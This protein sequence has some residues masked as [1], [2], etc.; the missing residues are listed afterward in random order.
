MFIAFQEQW[1]T[2]INGFTQTY[3]NDGINIFEHPNAEPGETVWDV[4]RDKAQ[5]AVSKGALRNMLENRRS[6]V[7]LTHGNA[8]TKM[9]EQFGKAFRNE[10]L[11]WTTKDEFQPAP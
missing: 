8:K 7:T 2:Y 6:L 10:A 4:L 9:K 3:K 11:N 1:F 5:K